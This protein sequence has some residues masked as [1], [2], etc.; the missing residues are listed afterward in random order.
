MGNGR[1]ARVEWIDFAKC[2]AIILV[3]VGHV[4]SWSHPQYK[5]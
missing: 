2:I 1:C 4:L 3:I 5:A